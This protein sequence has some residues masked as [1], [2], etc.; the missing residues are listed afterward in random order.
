MKIYKQILLFSL[1]TLFGFT[2]I[3]YSYDDIKPGT[4][5]KL[6]D[7]KHEDYFTSDAK[8]KFRNEIAYDI[9]FDNNYKS[10]NRDDEYK[11]TKSI[12]RLYSNLSFAK[13]FSL[14]STIHLERIANDIVGKDRTFDREGVYARE[15]NLAYDNKKHGFIVGKFD[16][17]FG[18]AWNFNRGIASH[19]IASNY[20]QNEKVGFG[21]I[22]RIGDLKKTGRYQL[23]YSFFKNDRKYLDNSVITKGNNVSKNDALPGDSNMLKSY[24][25]SADIDFDFGEYRKL[26][27]HFSYINLAVNENFSN[28]ADKNKIDDQKNFVASMNYTHPINNNFIFDSLIEYV[29]VANYQGNADIYERYLSANSILRI[30]KNYNLTLGYAIRQNIQADTFGFDENLSEISAGYDFLTSQFFDKLTMQFG[31]KH[32]RNDFKSSLETK[33]A[34]IALVRYQKRF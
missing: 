28:V 2:S 12:G 22:L 27:Y 4:F 20:L 7:G 29:D 21:Q 24:I 6:I 5:K 25:M 34:F 8:I 1:L 18:K 9:N 14:N 13:N 26:Y 16:L 19:E 17:N 32:Q 15:L 10:T 11:S 30:Y 3:A 23:S 31:Y 33:N